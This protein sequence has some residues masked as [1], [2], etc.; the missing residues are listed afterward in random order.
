[1]QRIKN[2]ILFVVTKFIEYI[3]ICHLKL[4]IEIHRQK[5]VFTLCAVLFQLYFIIGGYDNHY[6]KSTEIFTLSTKTFAS[7][8]DLKFVSYGS[9][10]T[11]GLISA[12]MVKLGPKEILVMGGDPTAALNIP[13]IF[14][15]IARHFYYLS[16]RG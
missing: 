1:M 13:L 10:V 2:I 9:V 8:D 3:L 7:S 15:K 4:S 14:S 16:F 12:C 11:T 6:L 5:Q